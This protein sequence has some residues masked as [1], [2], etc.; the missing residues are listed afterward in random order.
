MPRRNKGAYVAYRKDRGWYGVLEFI[1]GRRKWLSSCHETEEEARSA[2]L[3]ILIARRQGRT[4]YKDILVGSILKNYLDTHVPHTASPD[5]ARIYHRI[6]SPF[7]AQLKLQ[8]VTT[9]NCQK[10]CQMRSNQFKEKYGK[11]MSNA[12]LR[13]E[14]E[15]LSAA[16]NYAK[17]NDV[18]EKVPDIWKPSRVRARQRWLTRS[19]AAKLL[20]ASRNSEA[21]HLSLAILLGLYTGARIGAILNLRWKHIDF[22]NEVIDFRG[23]QKSNNKGYAVVPIPRNLMTF[24]RIKRDNEFTY[25]IN[26]EGKPIKSIKT[27]LATACRKA[28]LEDVTANVLRHTHASWLK[29]DGVASAFIASN[30][31]HSTPDMVDR[32]YGHMNQSYHD[33]I[34]NSKWGKR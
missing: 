19:E 26:L 1:D 29:Q 5:K 16:L 15:H 23:S 6:I 4:L 10:Y 25:V 30:M 18:I 7:W 31:G 3:D 12:S 34:K 13:R 32:T 11:E 27:S 2:L 8:E 24:L 14:L 17:K 28:E 22:H 20:W 21:E 33:V 9:A